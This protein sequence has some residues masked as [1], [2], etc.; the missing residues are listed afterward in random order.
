M[1]A[2]LV[3]GSYHEKDSSD[4][5]FQICARH[6]FKDAFPRTKP[7]LLEPIMGMDIECP[8]DFQGQVAGDIVARRGQI[9]A[10]DADGPI[11]SITAEVPLA[12]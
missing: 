1:R 4:L 3:D 2:V 8:M 6:C 7:V 11:A 12:A 9:V 10:T 5:A